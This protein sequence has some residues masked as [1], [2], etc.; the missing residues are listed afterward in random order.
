M[1]KSIVTN[2]TICHGVTVNGPRP[3]SVDD[4]DRRGVKRQSC[5]ETKQISVR[6]R[7]RFLTYYAAI[8][9]SRHRST[10]LNTACFLDKAEYEQTAEEWRKNYK[11]VEIEVSQHKLLVHNDM[12]MM[13]FLYAWF[14]YTTINRLKYQYV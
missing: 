7:R 6:H 12:I 2:V 4:G 13:K 3:V 14:L 10:A 9:S 11:K 8:M 1:T 5:G